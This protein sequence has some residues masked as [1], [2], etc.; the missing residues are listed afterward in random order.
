MFKDSL[1]ESSGRLN[2]ERAWTTIGPF[3]LQALLIAA[4]VLIPLIYTDV[5]PTQQLVTFLVAPHPPLAA[6]PPPAMTPVKALKSARTEI[7][8]GQLHT[9]TIVPAKV[10]LITEEAAPPI[11]SGGELGG[12]PGGVTGGQIAGTTDVIGE[13]V[14]SATPPAP[15][16]QT[17]KGIRITE[18]VQEG[19]LISQVEPV[20][21]VIARKAHI[22]GVVVLRAK[23][24]E[25]GAIEDLRVISG[26][27]IFVPNAIEAV[28]HW[29]YRPYY[30]NG[31][32]VAV[33]MTIT[34][35]FTGG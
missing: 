4:S 24:S 28:R 14:I 6:P 17:P 22:Q 31:E 30:L 10:A 5:L 25:Q 34:V 21:P 29:R 32:P 13:I 16:L 9:P 35:N 18:G 12:V 26:H 7:I 11:A 2:T 23:V 15:R 1:L 20:Y 19:N 27:P 8:G 33:E 3:G